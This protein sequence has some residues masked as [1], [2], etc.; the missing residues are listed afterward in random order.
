MRI[1]IILR[2]QSAFILDLSHCKVY[3][4]LGFFCFDVIYSDGLYY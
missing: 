1:H 4:E 3:V 2:V